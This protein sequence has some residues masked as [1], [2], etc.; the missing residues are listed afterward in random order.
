MSSSEWATGLSVIQR[1][2]AELQAL[3][4]RHSDRLKQGKKRREAGQRI[5]SSLSK[6]MAHMSL[7]RRHIQEDK[8]ERDA[9]MARE[10]HLRILA[11]KSYGQCLQTGSHYDVP[12]AFRVVQLW[13][14]HVADSD[15]VNEAEATLSRAPSHKFL[16]LI[17]QV[18]SRASANP[19]LAESRFQQV[20]QG[21]LV[22]VCCEHPFQSV[23]KVLALR[24]GNRGRDGKAVQASAVGTLTYVADEDKVAAAT[25]VIQKAAAAGPRCAEIIREL[26]EAVEGYIDLAARAVQKDASK[27]PFPARFKRILT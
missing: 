20:L 13:L 22:R 12:C 7:L 26:E 25:K 5:D 3:Q 11:L 18:A 27:M 21:L 2:E 17:Y 8:S 14:H 19:T 10:R 4:D 15:V 1:K 16:P 23:L 6:I 24:N 9:L